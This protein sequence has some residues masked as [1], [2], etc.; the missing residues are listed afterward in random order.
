MVCSIAALESGA[1][2]GIEGAEAEAPAQVPCSGAEQEGGATIDQD[3]VGQAHCPAWI[4][5]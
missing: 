1:M 4:V 5:S 2:R 3:T